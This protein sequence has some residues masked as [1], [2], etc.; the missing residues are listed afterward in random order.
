[1][2]ACWRVFEDVDLRVKMDSISCYT[3]C[4]MRMFVDGKLATTR[5]EDEIGRFLAE[6]REKCMSK[7][8]EESSKSFLR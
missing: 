3:D 7:D 2:G 8:R 1:M 6:E 4:E 5:F